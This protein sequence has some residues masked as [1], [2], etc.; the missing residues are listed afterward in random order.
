MC[1]QNRSKEVSG[2]R[3]DNSMAHADLFFKTINHD[4]IYGLK[5]FY[6]VSNSSRNFFGPNRILV[7]Y[8]CQ[9]FVPVCA[10]TQKLKIAF[11]YLDSKVHEIGIIWQHFKCST[12]FISN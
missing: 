10:P 7:R 8:F 5:K 3:V 12:I 11:Q 9:K 4:K 6:K 1:I 2:T